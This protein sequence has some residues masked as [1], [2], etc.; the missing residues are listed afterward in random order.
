MNILTIP[1]RCARQKWPRVLALLC[2][3][4]LGVAS[5]AALYKVSVA[6]GEGFEKKLTAFGANIIISP[7][8]ETLTV[9]YGVLLVTKT[10][11]R[12]SRSQISRIS[13][14]MA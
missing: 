5:I 1:L 13:F 3:F 2:I 14:S 10:T 8:R 12:R 11:V 4:M 7:K 9:S 6:V